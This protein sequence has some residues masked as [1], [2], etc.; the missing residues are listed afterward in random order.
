MI[1][2]PEHIKA[3]RP[4]TPGKP[5]EELERELGIKNPIKLASNENPIGPSPAAVRA[6]TAGL[7]KTLNRYPDGNGYYLKNAL[8]KKLSKN[9][10]FPPFNKGGQ[11]EIT[12]N[13]TPENII[14]G[15]GSNELLDIAAR[16]FLAPGDEAIMAH[17]SF[18]VYAMAVQAAGGKAIQSPLRDYRHDLDAMLSAVTPKTKMLFIANPNNPT[19]TMNTK[20]EF[21]RLMRK[22]RDGILVVVDEAYYEY[23]NDTRYADSFKHFRAG[24]DIL[25][26]RTFSKIYGLAGLRIGYGIARQDIITEMN[27]VRAP[28]NTNSV[29]Q[30]AAIEALK[31]KGHIKKSREINNKGKK[32]LY[33][34]L[35]SLGISYA[36]TEANFIY[37]PAAGSMDIY[38]KLLYD[39]VIVRPTGPDAIRVT[40]GL[41]E[42]NKKFIKAM[43][44]VMRNQ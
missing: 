1:N 11:R 5:I 44:T 29:A 15:N 22:I 4:Y 12:Y 10:P 24:R 25:I 28:F 21:D 33:K 2:V 7:K 3:L 30:K 18:V 9:P 42:E 13:I 20:G 17:P 41:P 27:K 23:V 34:E 8:A 36:P 43:K 40:I 32:Y 35:S 16:A 39:G 31:D 19:G 38:K 14:L 37:I 6:I 26:L